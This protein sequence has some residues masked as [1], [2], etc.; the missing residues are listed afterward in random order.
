MTI[1]HIFLTKEGFFFD[2]R[3]R[4]GVNKKKKKFAD[5]SARTAKSGFSGHHKLFTFFLF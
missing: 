3:D 4:E 5:M 2:V 1:I